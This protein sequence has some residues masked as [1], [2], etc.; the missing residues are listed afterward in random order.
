MGMYTRF[1]VSCYI[2][3][4]YRRLIE[5][6][7]V[8]ENT[9]K[10]AYNDDYESF[11]YA[12]LKEFIDPDKDMQRI[13]C[14]PHFYNNI[15]VTAEPFENDFNYWTGL[16]C[17]QCNFKNG[18]EIQYFIEHVLPEICESVI[19]CRHWYEEDDDW[20]HEIVECKG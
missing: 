15:G 20:T 10:Q 9:W 11:K 1:I 12:W 5:F 8:G 14:I 7:Q 16:W 3:E 4:E 6:I 18:H 17:F 19:E 2:K 13:N